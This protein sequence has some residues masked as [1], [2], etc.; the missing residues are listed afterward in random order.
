[1]E[2]AKRPRKRRKQ[3]VR[4]SGFRNGERGFFLLISDRDRVWRRVRGGR[5]H[6]PQWGVGDKQRIKMMMESLDKEAQAERR[7]H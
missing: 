2:K 6:T 1:M 3:C 4:K 5:S 7:E